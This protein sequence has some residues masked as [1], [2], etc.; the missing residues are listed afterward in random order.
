MKNGI[1]CVA[2]LLALFLLVSTS[3]LFAQ[4]ARPGAKLPAQ[5]NDQFEI[6]KVGR[7][8]ANQSRLQGDA[9]CL[10]SNNSPD[11]CEAYG[12]NIPIRQSS[13][14]VRSLGGTSQTGQQ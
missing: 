1:K 12:N 4:E 11:Y 9:P 14:L 7:H 5:D 6:T 2:N 13:N 8:G 3:P 10:G